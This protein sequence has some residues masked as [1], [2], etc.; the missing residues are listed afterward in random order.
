[1]TES[2][3]SI[4]F[5]PPSVEEFC[6]IRAK[7]GW[8]KLNK[9]L[10]RRSLRNGLFNVV[11]KEQSTLIG[12]ARVVGDGAMYFYVQDVTVDPSYQGKGLGNILMRHV[13]DYLTSVASKGATVGLLA[14]KGKESFYQK[15][16]YQL[17]PD[18]NLGNGMC[19]FFLATCPQR[20]E[21]EKTIV[22]DTTINIITNHLRRNCVSI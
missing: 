8:G 14:A 19:K 21:D 18:E 4:T 9:E 3:L 11:I 12:M 6:T 22:N 5:E 20:K 17:R 2:E 13:E 15:F 10:A 1:M 7:I 16:G